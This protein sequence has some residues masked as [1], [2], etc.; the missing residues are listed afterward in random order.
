[1]DRLHPLTQQFRDYHIEFFR[2]YGATSAGVQWGDEHELRFRYGKIGEILARDADPPRNRPT[3][4]DVGCGWGGLL[5]RLEDMAIDVDYSGVDVVPEM[6]Q[7]AQSHFTN[8]N[9]ILGDIFGLHD[10]FDYVVACGVLTQKLS[11]TIPEMERF[12]N[13]MIRKM[14]ALARHGIAVNLMSTHVNYMVDNLYYR[15]PVEFLAFCF[16]ELSPR[17]V[18]EHGYS[19]LGRDS[20]KLYDYIVY[21]YKSDHR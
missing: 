20:G 17:V 2:K 4:L 8:G 11:A 9:F 7:Y 15:N 1:M 6:V 13:D 5:Q 16:S 19:S 10:R 3:L 21:V 14:F 18:V 12:A